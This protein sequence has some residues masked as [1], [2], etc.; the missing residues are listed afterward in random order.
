MDISSLQVPR[1]GRS[2]FSKALPTPPDFDEE[3]NRKATPTL[4]GLPDAP[5]PP[6]NKPALATSISTPSLRSKA[7]DSPLPLLPIMAEPPRPRAQA[8]PIARKPVAQLPTPPASVEP[9]P[10][11]KAAKR[12]SSI[13]SLLSA[14]SRSSSDWAQRSSHESDFTKESE[15]SYSP[16]REATDI[17]P[18]VP[19]KNSLETTHDATSDKASEITSYTII[20]NFPPPPPLKNPSRPRTPSGSKQPSDGPKDGEGGSSSLSPPSSL[21]SGS[22][23]AGRE[24]WRRRASSRSDA[25][26]VITELKLPSSNGSTA[27]TASTSTTSTI[28]PPPKKTELPSTLPPLPPPPA[29]PAKPGQQQQKLPPPPPPPKHQ[30]L[31]PPPPTQQQ[32]QQQSITS[33]PPRSASLPGRNIRPVKQAESIDKGDEMGKFQKLKGLLRRDNGDQD[34]D[35]KQKSPQQSSSKNQSRTIGN[36]AVYKPE[37]PAKASSMQPQDHAPAPASVKASSLSA[38]SSDTIV[39]PVNESGKATGAAIPRRPVGAVSRPGINT[40]NVVQNPSTQTPSTLQ[41][42]TPAGSL[43]HPRQRQPRPQPSSSALPQQPQSHRPSSPHG[44]TSPTGGT[45]RSG[46]T[47]AHPSQSSAPTASSVGF[48]QGPGIISASSP[49]SQLQSQLSKSLSPI[50]KDTYSLRD[51]LSSPL[52][53]V[54]ATPNASFLSLPTGPGDERAAAAPGAVSSPATF[55]ERP[56]PLQSPVTGP[57]ADALAR[58]PRNTQCQLQCTVDGVWPANPLEGRHY[59]CHVQHNKLLPSRNLTYPLACQ[60][61]GIADAERRFM[62]T[63]CNL[64]ICVPCSDV[65]VANGRDLRVTMGILREKGMMHDWAQYPKRAGR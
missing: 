42:S 10:K 18:P 12:Q 40:P 22:P 16:E 65:L 24:I 9:K 50:D 43:P 7:Y 62:C 13:S 38:A 36:T 45:P 6:M 39:P 59:N 4:R 5:R 44:P 52:P 1:A 46:S 60:T 19:S 54:S 51:L 25:G 32:Q 53:A 27:S 58:F 56:S 41:P 64:R 49:T 63:F 55:G 48:H 26:L 15:P 17:L 8:G 30:R 34:G 37:P 21:T 14:Y 31:P 3:F 33:L 2:R 11:T 23:R 61:C 20:D 47:A 35:E 57:V 29:L 28:Q